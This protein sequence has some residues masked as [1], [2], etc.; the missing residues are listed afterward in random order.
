M[1]QAIPFCY[2]DGGRDLY[3]IK[4]ATGDCCCRSIAIA[5]G[6]PY[7]IILETINHYAKSE[8]RT[9]TKRGISNG[10]T[11]VYTQTAKKVMLKLGMIWVPTMFI[12]QGCKVHLRREELP[13]GRLVA[14]VSGHYTAVINGVLH[15]THDCSREGNRCVYG[16]FIAK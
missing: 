15:D 13:K 5:T 16:Y 14:V 10:R 8:R 6:I 1:S 12:G 11:G 7:P 2:N 3:E 9:A 4:G